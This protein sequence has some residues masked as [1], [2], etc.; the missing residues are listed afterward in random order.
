MGTSARLLQM[1]KEICGPRFRARYKLGRK[2]GQGGMGSVY[3]ATDE[4]LQRFLAVKFINKNVLDEKSA[5]RFL[6]EAKIAARLHH[7]NIVQLFDYDEDEGHPYLAFQ[8]IEGCCLRAFLEDN[9]PP[10]LAQTKEWMAQ[11][12]SAMSAAHAAGI[13][14]RD[15][16][17]DNILLDKNGTLLVTDFGLARRD[18][19]TAQL[20]DDGSILGTP[21]YI[22]PELLLGEKPSVASDIYAAGIILYE[23]LTG[24]RP[25]KNDQMMQ[26]LNAHMKESVPDITLKRPELP[27]LLNGIVRRAMAK[28]PEER[29]QSFQDLTNDLK[30]VPEQAMSTRERDTITTKL[31]ALS[32]PAVIDVPTRKKHPLLGVVLIVVF[33]FIYFLWPKTMPADKALL[34]TNVLKKDHGFALSWQSERKRRYQ[35]VLTTASGSVVKKEGETANSRKHQFLMQRLAPNTSYSIEIKDQSGT[36]K[37]DFKTPALKFNRG[38]FACSWRGFTYIDFATNWWSDFEVCLHAQG[39]RY[40]TRINGSGAAVLLPKGGPILGKAQQS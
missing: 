11:L 4:R 8:F 19:R 39:K 31:K 3:L 12:C 35:F 6:E 22:A 9:G 25:F 14:H 7:R 37:K 21:E 30:E 27:T 38:V 33:A 40:S 13:V 18:D 24:E 10:A 20:T 5:A 2:L 15:L 26:L 16:K 36:V 1:N 29:Y 28:E 17:G 32:T 23:L 34:K